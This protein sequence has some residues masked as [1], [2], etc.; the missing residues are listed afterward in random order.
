MTFKSKCKG[1]FVGKWTANR[2]VSR[3][4]WV[5]L[6]FYG[7]TFP[8]AW[9]MTHLGMGESTAIQTGINA[10]RDV[11]IAWLGVQ[12]IMDIIKG[13]SGGDHE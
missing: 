12:G 1:L 10:V 2:L 3:K 5:V 9:G 6:A 8:F 13:K 11:V 4:F 7:G